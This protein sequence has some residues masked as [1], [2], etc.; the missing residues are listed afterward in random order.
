MAEAFT[1][2][3]LSETHEWR[4][5]GRRW[6]LHFLPNDDGQPLRPASRF[7]A[8]LLNAA[9]R[10]VDAARGVDVGVVID[11][12]LANRTHPEKPPQ[13]NMTAEWPARGVAIPVA[14]ELTAEQ[15]DSIVKTQPS[16]PWGIGSR[17][18]DALNLA[19]AVWAAAHGVAIPPAPTGWLIY[20]HERIDPFYWH[21]P[22]FDGN[23]WNNRPIKSKEPVFTAP[24]RDTP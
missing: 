11:K 5:D 1:A 7:E 14:S 20:T 2:L 3:K 4:L 9:K 13:G 21:G 24:W 10:E 17:K 15:F 16:Q 23:E 12:A 6:W 8:E 22:I 19:R 18:V